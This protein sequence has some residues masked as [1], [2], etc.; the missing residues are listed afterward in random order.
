M[1]FGRPCRLQT[2]SMKSCASS[3]EVHSFV[4]GARTISLLKRSTTVRIESYPLET[5][6]SV[7]KSAVRSCHGP[8]GTGRG[9]SGPVR[10]WLSPL[11]LAQVW[12]PW[13]YLLT[14]P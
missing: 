9:L 12:H 3:W 5:G 14:S 6:R 10:F 13:T 7:T 2:L 4:V 11:N 1:D 8:A